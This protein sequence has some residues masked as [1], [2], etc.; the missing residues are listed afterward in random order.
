MIKIDIRHFLFTNSITL[1]LCK[2]KKIATVLYPKIRLHQ[3][4]YI[5]IKSILIFR[6]QHILISGF[7]ILL[8]LNLVIN[9]VQ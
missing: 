8:L 6:L 5:Y 7:R 4:I 2:Q 9:N 3:Y 1:T